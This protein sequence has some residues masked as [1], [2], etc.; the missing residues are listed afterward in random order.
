MQQALDSS[1][2]AATDHNP[3]FAHASN[4]CPR[5]SRAIRASLRSL[6]AGNY[7]LESVVRPDAGERRGRQ[8]PAS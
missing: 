3:E 7:V 5:G 8:A 1:D 6:F 2:S 4:V